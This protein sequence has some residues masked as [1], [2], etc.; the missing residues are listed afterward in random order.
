MLVVVKLLKNQE[1]FKLHYAKEET[2]QPRVDHSVFSTHL[3]RNDQRLQEVIRAANQ[4]KNT[5]TVETNLE[6]FLRYIDGIIFVFSEDQG[7]IL[8]HRFYHKQLNFTISFQKNWQI[9][10][11][12]TQLLAIRQDQEEIFILQ[13]DEAEPE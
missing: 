3:L 4:F 12:P 11:Q 7:I 6:D 10:N 1:Q 8:G 5:D 2:R 9:D 13:I